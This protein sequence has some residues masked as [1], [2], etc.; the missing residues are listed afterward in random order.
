MEAIRSVRNPSNAWRQFSTER[1]SLLWS[2]PHG[3]RQ[4]AF[5][6][7]PAVVLAG[8]VL[9]VADAVRIE[10]HDVARF[11]FEFGFLVV[12]VVEESDGHAGYFG[13]QYFATPADERRCGT[14]VG[15]LE[16]ALTRSPQ[17]GQKRDVLRRHLA[18][19]E[20]FIKASEKGGGAAARGETSQE[21][22]EQRAVKRRRG[23]LAARVAKRQ[24][25]RSVVVFKEVVEVTADDRGGFQVHAHFEAGNGGRLGGEDDRSAVS[26]RLRD[27]AGCRARVAASCS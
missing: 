16:D 13:P 18:L 23:A 3:C 8:V 6:P 19:H 7:S 10:Q 20:V 15:D 27:P 24:H 4:Y 5:Q 21:S 2:F 9:L 17:H 11:G 14:R 26:V 25:G 22:A 12:H 1:Y